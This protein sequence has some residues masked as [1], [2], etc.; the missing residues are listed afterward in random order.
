MARLGALHED[1]RREVRDLV[2]R[3]RSAT[4][5]VGKRVG[6][7]SSTYEAR[8][9]QNGVLLRYEVLNGVATVETVLGAPM[10][11]RRASGDDAFGD[12]GAL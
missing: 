5:P 8:L 9:R 3:V 4:N 7:Q 12:K 1:D 6:G 11:E 10:R 2:R